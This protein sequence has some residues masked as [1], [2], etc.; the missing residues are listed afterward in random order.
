MRTKLLLV[1]AL[2]LSVVGI[3]YAVSTYTFIN[4][5]NGAAIN[6]SSNKANCLRAVMMAVNANVPNAFTCSSDTCVQSGTSFVKGRVYSCFDDGSTD[7][8]GQP[9][10]RCKVDGPYT[11]WRTLSYSQG[12]RVCRISPQSCYTFGSC[13]VNGDPLMYA[14]WGDAPSTFAKVFP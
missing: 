9:G 10:R 12:A 11:T 7:S 2:S 8:S 4:S 14:G 13:S 5:N 6:G 1:L 3:A